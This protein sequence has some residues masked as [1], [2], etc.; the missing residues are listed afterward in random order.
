MSYAADKKEGEELLKECRPKI[1]MIAILPFK[2]L[3]ENSGANEEARAAIYKGLSEIDPVKT[4]V[5]IQPLEE[6]DKELA[7]LGITGYSGLAGIPVKKLGEALHVDAVIIG[8]VTTYYSPTKD[9]RFINAILGGT[10]LGHNRA[11]AVVETVMRLYYCP[12]EKEIWYKVLCGD[13]KPLAFNIEALAT[14]MKS[15]LDTLSDHMAG[16]W[17]YRK[18]KP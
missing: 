10:I 7:S 9:D 14:N 6:T 18:R 15:A 13:S 5:Q 1:K 17:P 11:R 4:G 12:E 8:K 3:T 2:D 16:C